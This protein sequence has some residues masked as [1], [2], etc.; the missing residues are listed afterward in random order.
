MVDNGRSLKK[1]IKYRWKTLIG[2]M[3]YLWSIML[4]PSGELG[5]LY[6]Y[7]KS[8]AAWL[9]AVGFLCCW[10]CDKGCKRHAIRNPIGMLAHTMTSSLSI[11]GSLCFVVLKEFFFIL[12][13]IRNKTEDDNVSS[14]GKK[15]RDVF[16]Q[17]ITYTFKIKENEVDRC[18]RKWKKKVPQSWHHGKCI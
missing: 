17:F 6:D 1:N 2:T 3:F 7:L 13:F 15:K 4:K 8:I 16:Y 9:K 5:I 12:F 14:T 11:P 18:W 10:A